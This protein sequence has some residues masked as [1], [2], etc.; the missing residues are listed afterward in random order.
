MPP[1]LLEA[2]KEYEAA[3]TP[4]NTMWFPGCSYKHGSITAASKDQACFHY[5]QIYLHVQKV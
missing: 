1:Q 5:K 2:M 3:H 4:S